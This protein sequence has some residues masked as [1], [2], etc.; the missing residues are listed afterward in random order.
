[1]QAACLSVP[2]VQ[3]LRCVKA[4]REATSAAKREAGQLTAEQQQLRRQ[5][6]SLQKCI[7]RM[8]HQVILLTTYPNTRGVEAYLSRTSSHLAGNASSIKVH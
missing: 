4:L 8:Q 3:V 5:Q 6:S 7:Q 1:M 2:V